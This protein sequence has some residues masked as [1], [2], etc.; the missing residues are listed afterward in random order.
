MTQLPDII[1]LAVETT[2]PNEILNPS[3][4]AISFSWTSTFILLGSLFNPIIYCWR[5]K[6]LRRAFQ[7]IC[8]VRQPENRAPDIEMM[9]VQHYRPEIQPSACEAFSMAVVKQEP[10]LLSFS[11]LKAEEIVHIEEM[12]N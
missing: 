11:H 10:V 1:L 8:H 12:D 9:D 5:N 7:E 6:K 2:L 4:T 3:V